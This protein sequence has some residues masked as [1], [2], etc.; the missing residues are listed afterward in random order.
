MSDS[1]SQYPTGVYVKGDKT[2]VARRPSQAVAL[3]F[4]GYVLKKGQSANTVETDLNGS[5]ELEGLVDSTVVEGDVVDPD[6]SKMV[7]EGSPVTAVPT[8]RPP[9]R[10][11][12]DNQ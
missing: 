4:Q 9:R 12:K 6:A 1:T 3:V 11:K 2:R 8:P 7:A 5:D 10:S